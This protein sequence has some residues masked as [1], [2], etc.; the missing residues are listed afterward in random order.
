MEKGTTESFSASPRQ[1][2]DQPTSTGDGEEI[3]GVRAEHT[4]DT[5]EESLRLTFVRTIIL[6]RMVMIKAIMFQKDVVFDL[7]EIF[8]I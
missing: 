8:N 3:R 4:N 6:F 1:D 5:R 2:V 7:N